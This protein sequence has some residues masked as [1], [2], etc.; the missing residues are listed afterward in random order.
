MKK[1]LQFMLL[2][3]LVTALVL[4]VAGCQDGASF[5]IEG[6]WKNTGSY[7]F[8]QAQSG[9]I[10]SFDGTNCNVF[11]P[12]DTYAFYRDGSDY[13]LECTSLLF[14]QNVTFTVKVVDQDHMQIYYGSNCL[15]MTRVN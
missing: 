3:V 12:R 7:T 6:K 13:K 8:G 2:V 4:T 9:S 14:S 5:T 11:S 10:V 15:E 1:Q